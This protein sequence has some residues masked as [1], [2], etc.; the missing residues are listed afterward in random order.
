MATMAG[1]WFEPGYGRPDRPDPALF[2]LPS[3]EE[4]ER[5]LRVNV[6]N[7][8]GAMR[9]AASSGR[10]LAVLDCAES[11]HWFSDRWVHGPHW[12]EVFT[13][14]AQAAAALGDL[15]QQA[16]QLNYLAWVHWVPPSDPEAMLRYAAEALDLATRGDAMAQIAWSH[17]YAGVALRLLGRLDEAAA[18]ASSAAETFKSTGDVDAYVQSLAS[19]G[20]CLRDE[21]RDTEALEQFRK[22][23]A[24]HQILDGLDGPAVLVGHSYGGVVITEA[25]HHPNVAALAYITAFAPDKGESVSS[26]SVDPPP[27]AP[28]PPILPPS[29]GFLFLD[30]DKFAASFAADLPENVAAFMADSQVPWG[31]DALE[32]AVSEP[33]W[34]AKPSWY[35]V[36]TDDRMI[37]PPAQRF[38]SERAKATVSETPGSHAVYVSRPAVVAA[39]IAQATQALNYQS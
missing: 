27:G 38:M 17:Q 16:T 37:P 31:V 9:A 32:G 39:V 25:G 3:A 7:W 24:T 12:H 13:L 20:D 33:A 23:L 1:R 5:W 11:M 2:I 6:D 19:F 35:L 4:A 22:L 30:R 28:V 21:G 34:Q 8:V 10:H 36:A 26:L 29:N 15:A 14:G 18:S